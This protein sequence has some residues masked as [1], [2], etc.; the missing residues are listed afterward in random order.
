MKRE[1]VLEDDSN[2]F[3]VTRIFSQ[4]TIIPEKIAIIAPKERTT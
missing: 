4:L 3:L 2:K 1:S